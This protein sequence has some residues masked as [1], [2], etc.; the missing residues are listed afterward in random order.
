MVGEEAEEAGGGADGGTL[1]VSDEIGG[2]T[3]H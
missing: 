2:N 1:R 3:L